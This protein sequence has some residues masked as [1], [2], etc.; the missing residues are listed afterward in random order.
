MKDLGHECVMA[1][2]IQ[3]DLKE[4]YIK[5]QL[6]HPLYKTEFSRNCKFL[7]KKKRH[8]SKLYLR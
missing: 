1:S 6:N 5:N 3:Q 2:E 8:S 7:Y 4:L